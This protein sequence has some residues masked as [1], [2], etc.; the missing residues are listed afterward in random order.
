MVTQKNIEIIF[1]ENKTRH[2]LDEKVSISRIEDGVIVYETNT[3]PMLVIAIEHLC[4]SDV[5]Y[6]D[7]T[8]V[9]DVIGG[10]KHFSLSLVGASHDNELLVV[11]GNANHWH[12]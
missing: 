7:G 4:F 11:S 12:S 8:T 10:E 2:L 9:L 6:F 3:K 5:D 1:T